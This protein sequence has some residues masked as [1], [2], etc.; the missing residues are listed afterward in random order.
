MTTIQRPSL[1][2]PAIT[3][4]P[5]NPLQ[6]VEAIADLL[7]HVSIEFRT[8]YLQ[9]NEMHIWAIEQVAAGVPGNLWAWIELS[10]YPS[11]ITAAFWGAI[12]GGGGPS[13][14]VVP[15]MV[16]V[17]PL[18]EVAT[19]IN[20]VVHNVFLPWAIHSPWA[21]LV[22]QTPVAAALPNAFW[23]VQAYF[24]AKKA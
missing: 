7:T 22:V 3:T 1:V 12:G 2:L 5:P 19:G 17:A 10:P 18:I 6:D 23:V 13:Y 14:P 8:E 15:A 9:D 20:N 21:R 11:T 4:R 16:P 24:S